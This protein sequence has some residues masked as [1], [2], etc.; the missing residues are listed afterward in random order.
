M[1][2]NHTSSRHVR[3]F[4]CA[5]VVA[6]ATLFVAVSSP[7]AFVSYSQTP[8]VQPQEY[9]VRPGERF[10]EVV[11]SDF[12]AG[13]MGDE[14]RLERGMKFCEEV[15]SKNPKHAEALVW[16]GGGLLTRA[17]HAYTKGD[18]ALGERL[19]ERGLKE[20]DDAIAFEPD[21]MGVMIGRAATLVGLA[22]S[23]WDSAD[24]RG[25]QLLASAVSDYEKV[26]RL[27]RPTFSA[28]SNHSRGELLFGL[29]SGWS[30]LGEQSKAREYLRLVL[31]ECRG[32]SYETEARGWLKKE[33]LPVVQ[34]DCTGCHV[35]KND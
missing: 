18:T 14:A 8:G 6:C 22:Q 7:R 10:D 25:R 24:P 3:S 15:L 17:S 26:Y 31:Q 13:M 28:L 12:F 1:T 11:R 9:K 29:A 35:S 5:L 21:N 2:Y 30:M 23:G 27:Q 4:K 34:H 32:T 19:W 16:H 20:L 33:P